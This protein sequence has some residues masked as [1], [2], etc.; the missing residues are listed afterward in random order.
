[1]TLPEIAR[2][3]EAALTDSSLEELDAELKA[4]RA[5]L[6][7]GK[8]SVAVTQAAG[9]SFHLWAA[10]GDLQDILTMLPG[11]EAWARGRGCTIVTVDGRRGWSRAL[12]PFGFR[13]VE[14]ELRKA[15]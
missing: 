13:E 7:I 2:L 8:S 6:W 5:Q 12:R 9:E 1:M 14:G 15:L 4:G 3:L 10:A 11:A